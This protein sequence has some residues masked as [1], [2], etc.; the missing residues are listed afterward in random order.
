MHF[1]LILL[2]ENHDFKTKTLKNKEKTSVYNP[3]QIT[4]YYNKGFVTHKN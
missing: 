4:K 3:N 1:E 2:G